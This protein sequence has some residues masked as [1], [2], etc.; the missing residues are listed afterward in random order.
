MF[1]EFAA[2]FSKNRLSTILDFIVSYE[3][4][5]SSEE[6]IVFPVSIHNR[7]DEQPFWVSRNAIVTGVQSFAFGPEIEWDRARFYDNFCGFVWGIK[8]D[9][10]IFFTSIRHSK[11]FEV[12]GLNLQE[13][14]IFDTDLVDKNINYKTIN[15]CLVVNG[16]FALKNSIVY[17]VDKDHHLESISWP[18]NFP[19]HANGDLKIISGPPMFDE[20]INSAVLF[21][22]SSSWFHF[23][24]DALPSLLTLDPMDNSEKTLIVRKQLP[25]NIMTIVNRL[26]FSRVIVMRDGQTLRV[27]KLE[28]MTDL[29]EKSVVDI[30]ARTKDVFNVRTFLSDRELKNHKNPYIFIERDPRLFRPLLN[31]EKLKESL[32]ELGFVCVRPESLNLDEQIELFAGAKF[33]VAESGAALT[34]II[35]MKQNSF[36]VELSGGNNNHL[37]LNLSRIFG[38]NHQI[39][40]GKP[41]FLSNKFSGDGAFKVDVKSV[42]RYIKSQMY[43]SNSDQLRM[44]N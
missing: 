41:S 35:F 21:G 33:I 42:V 17:Y 31:N 19:F 7:Q 43:D 23:L 5:L 44:I 34:N 14:L 6:S 16:L 22:S 29:R 38:I 15:D 20:E 8:N 40:F 2:R 37:W 4:T 18:T 24:V 30:A 27:K 9:A 25:Q 36:V 3:A 39:I 13:G 28:M 11:S 26:G 12:R 32:L 1:R 10:D